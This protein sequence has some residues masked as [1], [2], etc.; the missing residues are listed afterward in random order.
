M[1]FKL[2]LVSV[3]LMCVGVGGFTLD[4]TSRRC[5]TC[6]GNSK[7]NSEE[8]NKCR[9]FAINQ[10]QICT[11]G[12]YCMTTM[13]GIYRSD[14]SLGGAFAS[15]FCSNHRCLDEFVRAAR[16]NISLTS[17]TSCPTDYCNID[18]F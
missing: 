16:A 1:Y 5:Y 9:N 18:R 6:Y 13:G 10:A 4:F 8:F 17:C 7:D 3:A 14:G 11:P 15:R 12:G 2:V